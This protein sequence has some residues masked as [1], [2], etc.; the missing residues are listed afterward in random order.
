M[1]L[2]SIIHNSVVMVAVMSDVPLFSTKML[3]SCN[4]N[5]SVMDII[6]DFYE[7]AYF[8]N[9]SKPFKSFF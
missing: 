7:K 3:C 6:G 2:D 1:P 9:I 4:E 5:M 8:R